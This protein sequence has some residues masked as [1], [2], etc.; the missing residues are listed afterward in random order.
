[1]Y[2]ALGASFELTPQARLLVD[3]YLAAC[4][5]LGFGRKQVAS[6]LRLTEAQWARQIEG[7]D[8][9]HVS[10]YRLALS[11]ARLIRA[12]IKEIAPAYGLRVFDRQD[13]ICRVIDAVTL[14]IERHQQQEQ[15]HEE[16]R[17]A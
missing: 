6:H 13:D 1:M 3:A 7:S 2:F 12:W 14:L 17:S 10:L 5:S 8:G 11:P 15:P 9:Q 4:R 16:K